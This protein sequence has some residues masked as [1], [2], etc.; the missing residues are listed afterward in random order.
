MD[1]IEEATIASILDQ[2]NI[3]SYSKYGI[4]PDNGI[5]QPSS[6]YILLQQKIQL[7]RTTTGQNVETLLIVCSSTAQLLHL[8]SGNIADK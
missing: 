4:P 8:D 7:K 2:H 1:L 5:S 3:S 6:R